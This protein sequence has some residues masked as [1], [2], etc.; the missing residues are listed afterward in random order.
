MMR[1][2][3]AIAALGLVSA[4]VDFETLKQSVTGSTT[5][6]QKVVDSCKQNDLVH[7]GNDVNCHKEATEKLFCELLQRS[8]PDLAAAHCN[9]ATSLAQV[10]SKKQRLRN[11]LKALNDF[12]P[13]EDL[14][15][16]IRKAF[17]P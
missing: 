7:D 3:L 15:Q 14:S 17:A 11:A 1:T 13:K 12:D 10:Q 4:Q 5:F 6:Q 8:K 2:F 9:G 16:T